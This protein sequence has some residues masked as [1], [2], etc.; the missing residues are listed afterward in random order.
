MTGAPVLIMA[1]GTGG[2]VFPALAIATALRQ[3]DES[4]VWLGTG[5]GL[6]ARVVPA[7]GFPLAQIRV[8]G[9]R[10]RGL[11]A[12][13]VAPVQVLLA[14]ADALRVVR[15]H[16]PKVVLGMGG[17]A[18]GPGGLAAWL[19]RRPLVIHEQNA[20]AGLTNR[21]LAGFAR[22]VLEAFPGSFSGRQGTRV[23]GNPVRAEIAALAP[24]RERLAGRTGRLRL[25]VLGGSQ[26]ARALNQVVAPAVALLSAAERPEIRHQA[27][28]KTLDMA[29]EAY[30]SAG[31]EA[32]VTPFIADMA[33]AYGWA[34][35]V[36]SRSGALT[37]AELAAAGVAAL[38]VPYP[39]AV[40]D[41]QTRNAAS[42]VDAGAAT[43]LPEPGLTPERLAAELRVLLADREQV[44]RRSER[45]R[46]LARPAATEDIV[47]TCLA[48]SRCDA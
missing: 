26:G 16:R 10:R 20:V 41:H 1:G 21:L 17:Y 30:A 2:H 47:A 34:D 33:E 42:M 4:V 36:L 8:A 19:L 14:V 29:S 15:R 39:A 38:L 35:V 27:G 25:L 18:S 24:P 44:L 46:S 40:D 28:E 31:V 12:W 22:E 5:R 43:L 13:L 3:R 32:R 23:T 48:R 6:E 45:A 7:A 11:L 9:I 37:V